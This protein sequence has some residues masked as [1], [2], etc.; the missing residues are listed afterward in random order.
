MSGGHGQRH[1]GIGKRKETGFGELQLGG[2]LTVGGRGG[3]NVMIGRT[4]LTP[5]SRNGSKK[6]I[7]ATCSLKLVATAFSFDS[8]ET[9][10]ALICCSK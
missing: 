9:Q 4:T 2:G 8:S 7:G 10:S 3:H 5:A 1:V 6:G